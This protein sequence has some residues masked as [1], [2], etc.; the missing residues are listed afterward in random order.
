MTGTGTRE[1]ITPVLKELH[2]LPI[3]ARIHFKTLGLIHSAIHV[4]SAP[5]Y[6]KD[7][8]RKYVP[9]RNLRSSNDPYILVTINTSAKSL[10]NEGFKLWNELPFVLRSITCHESFK[11]KVKTHLFQKFYD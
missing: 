7:F 10:V 8:A 3:T 11:R 2:W 1:H 9:S 6:I 5:K 4:D